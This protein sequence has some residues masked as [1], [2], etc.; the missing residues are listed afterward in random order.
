MD[1]KNLMEDVLLTVKGACD[2]YLHGTIESATANV[3]NTFDQRLNETL[4]MQNEIYNKMSDGDRP[5]AADRQGQAEIRRERQLTDKPQ[6]KG[7][8]G[9]KA[10]RQTAVPPFFRVPLQISG[11]GCGFF[12]S[13][14]L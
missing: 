12:D 2:L 5:D 4:Q 10:A 11:G 8:R 13:A 7:P 14:L 9:L 1:D 3:H 6:R